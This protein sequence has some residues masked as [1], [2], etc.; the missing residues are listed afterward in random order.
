MLILL[1]GFIFIVK[2]V[3]SLNAFNGLLSKVCQFE[4]PIFIAIDC[5]KKIDEVGH[6]VGLGKFDFEEK[7]LYEVDVSE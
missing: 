2:L 5:L 1:K 3:Y 7:M 4:M 6:K